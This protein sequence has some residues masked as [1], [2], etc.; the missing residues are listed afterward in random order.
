MD[1]GALDE[2]A[3]ARRLGVHVDTLRRLIEQGEFPPGIPVSPR[4]KVWLPKDVDA[5]L[6]LKSR[7]PVRNPGAA[8]QE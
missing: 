1:D 6:H 4:V 5:Y 8:G 3:T 2:S 7:L